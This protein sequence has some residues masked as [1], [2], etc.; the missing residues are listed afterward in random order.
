M[1]ATSHIH[2]TFTEPMYHLVGWD[3][4][5]KVE[6]EGKIQL[7]CYT[8]ANQQQYKV[9]LKKKGKKRKKDE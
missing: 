4:W 1:Q 5:K 7:F 6:P 9:E 3:G 8:D 2:Y